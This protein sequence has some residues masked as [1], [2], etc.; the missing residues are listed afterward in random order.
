MSLLLTLN[1]ATIKQTWLSNI[2]PDLLSGLLMA[3]AMIPQAIAFAL[4]CGVDPMVGLHASF[5]IS[6]TGAL[7]GSR[8]GMLTSTSVVTALVLIGLVKNYGIEYMYAATVLM[9]MLQVMFGLLKGGNLI[10]FVP[11]S[12]VL[13]FVNALA[14]LLFISQL[15]QF[16]GATVT[17]YALVAATLAI[18]YLLPL[19]T[20]AIP[21]GLV[22][23]VAIT[24][25]TIFGHIDVKTVGDIGH[26]TPSLPSFHLPVVPFTWQTLMIIFPT[27]ISL[28]M[29][30]LIESLI[31]ATLLDEMTKTTSDKSVE[32]KGQGI[33][34]MIAGLFGGMGGCGITGLSV[35]NIKTGGKTRLSTLSAGVFMMLLVLFGTDFVRAIPIAGLVGLMIMVSISIFEWNTFTE[36][37]KMTKGCM[38]TLVA[39]MAV[40]IGTKDLALGTFVGVFISAMFFTWNKT[41]MDIVQSLV[42]TEDG[43][44]SIYCKVKGSLFFATVASFTA[45]LA[46]ETFL[47]YNLIINFED[48]QVW[49]YS[50]ASALMKLK[51][52]LA[53]QGHTL[54]LKGLSEE[55]RAFIHK[56]DNSF[57]LA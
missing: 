4:V 31:T 14:I 48:A 11:Q 50:A 22:A 6:V 10:S 7:V 27:A 3:L 13:G 40:I 9:G 18:I 28:A 2:Q 19:F 45:L 41:K 46:E 36:L 21:S 32:S 25:F 51:E 53:E 57:I 29:V 43:R 35:I 1:P 54:V 5:C 38:L 15:K 20:K 49:D 30:G 33:A 12:V 56:M 52:K 24:L 42:E 16:E 44:K 23:L 34:S 39:T 37:K 8:A 47:G 55:S 17:V 26:I